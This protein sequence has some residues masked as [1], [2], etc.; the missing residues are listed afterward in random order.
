[1]IGISLALG[2]EGHI[3]CMMIRVSLTTDLHVYAE[4]HQLKAVC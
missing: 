2:C 4:I 3:H 1:M